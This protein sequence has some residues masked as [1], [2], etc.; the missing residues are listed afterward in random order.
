MKTFDKNTLTIYT[1]LYTLRIYTTLYHTYQL[2]YGKGHIK[3]N[4][5]HSIINMEENK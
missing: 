1:T 2:L 5:S 4:R 3:V